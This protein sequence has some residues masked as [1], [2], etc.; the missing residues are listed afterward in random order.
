MGQTCSV[1][2]KG[3]KSVRRVEGGFVKD[4]LILQLLAQAGA[5][6]D[7]L[8][9]EGAL[10][11]ALVFG[12]EFFAGFGFEIDAAFVGFIRFLTAFSRRPT[13]LRVAG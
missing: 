1:Q 8:A 5:V 9:D 12:D 13:L 6:A 11:P 4:G 7:V 10:H 3:T 2:P